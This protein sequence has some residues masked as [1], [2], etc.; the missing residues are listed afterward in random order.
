[1]PIEGLPSED[2]ENVNELIAVCYKFFCVSDQDDRIS[3]AKMHALSREYMY[4]GYNSELSK[5][6]MDEIAEQAIIQLRDNT[7]LNEN[8]KENL[9]IQSER[10]CDKIHIVDHL[11]KEETETYN[12]STSEDYILKKGEKQLILG[13]FGNDDIK[14]YKDN[15][16]A[17]NEPWLSR[18]TKLGFF[19]WNIMINKAIMKCIS[20]H[21]QTLFPIQLILSTNPN[22][23]F[24]EQIDKNDKNIKYIGY[25]IARI[26]FDK[27]D[28]PENVVKECERLYNYENDKPPESQQQYFVIFIFKKLGIEFKNN[29]DRYI[30]TDFRL[31]RI[32][33]GNLTRSKRVLLIEI[34]QLMCSSLS[35]LEKSDNKIYFYFI[36]E[37]KKGT[38]KL[39]NEICKSQKEEIDILKIELKEKE[40]TYEIEKLKKEL[41]DKKNINEIKNINDE[42]NNKEIE[43]DKLIKKK[44]NNKKK[45]KDCYQAWLHEDTI[46]ELNQ[47]ELIEGKS[48]NIFIAKKDLR[49][50]YTELYTR[51]E[52]KIIKKEIFFFINDNS[53]FKYIDIYDKKENKKYILFPCHFKWETI[54]KKKTFILK[55]G[56]LKFEDKDL[57]SE[58][59]Y[60]EQLCIDNTC[61]FNRDFVV[62]PMKHIELFSENIEKPKNYD[63]ILQ[64][65][66]ENNLLYNYHEGGSNHINKI[67]KLIKKIKI[68][69]Y[70]FKQIILS[71]PSLYTDSYKNYS[72][73]GYNLNNIIYSLSNVK[74]KYSNMD[75]Y[76]DKRL[77][78]FIP[79]IQH[80]KEGNIL[81]FSNNLNMLLLCKKYLNI[82]NNN[83]F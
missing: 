79:F 82:K 8:Q 17:Y 37:Y 75:N 70:N 36:S 24:Y 2:I 74:I 5:K 25:F 34:Q 26:K 48:Y 40:I 49:E 23:L 71:N 80:I 29:I 66:K 61:I 65:I 7:K 9:R 27:L 53:D 15:P 51:N 76:I 67:N 57:E 35:L 14:Q 10:T 44:I 19:V 63:D 21:S 13:F 58:K 72:Y 56:N 4:S 33:W 46:K 39:V 20:D 73:I 45:N 62:H 68:Y 31:Q 3:W 54:K 69:K 43:L 30:L 16:Y 47:Y 11:K 28:I 78:Q 64:Q 38:N 42:I 83:I 22:H 6:I 41:K 81:I 32:H 59:F 1:M 52:E 12:S 77:L 50:L 60:K 18:S 55:H